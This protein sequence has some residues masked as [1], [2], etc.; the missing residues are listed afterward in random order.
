MPLPS[1]GAAAQAT[2][3]PALTPVR[4]AGDEQHGR[5]YITAN[6]W[7][8]DP[9]GC[10]EVSWRDDHYEAVL[11]RRG[12]RR[13]STVLKADTRYDAVT[14]ALGLAS[15]HNDHNYPERTVA[16]NEAAARAATS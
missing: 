14:E 10:V 12:V 7:L 11:Y 4:G 16:R 1:N 5:T 15:P 6:V 8:M 13:A 3:D 2:P 9:G